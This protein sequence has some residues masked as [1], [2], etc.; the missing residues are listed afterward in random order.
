MSDLHTHW[1]PATKTWFSLDKCEKCGCTALGG[2]VRH[3][4]FNPEVVPGLTYWNDDLPPELGY[5]ESCDLAVCDD[6]Y[7]ADD[8]SAAPPGCPVCG[9]PGGELGGL[10]SLLWYRCVNCGMDF[11][12]KAN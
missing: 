11:N 2:I 3:N 10:G 4:L 6:C 1:H 9:G 5:D 7:G 8:E 12:V